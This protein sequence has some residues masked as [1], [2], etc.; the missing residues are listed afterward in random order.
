METPYNENLLLSAGYGLNELF[1][2]SQAVSPGRR[3]QV[4]VGIQQGLG[5]WLEGSDTVDDRSERAR[6]GNTPTAYR[7][8]RGFAVNSS[9]ESV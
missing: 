1:G 4:E 5:R 6:A 9:S 7:D 3:N 8:G 2:E